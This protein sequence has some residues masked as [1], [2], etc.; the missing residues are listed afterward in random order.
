MDGIAFN[1]PAQAR[2]FSLPAQTGSGSCAA[3]YSTDTA[4]EM[5]QNE[6][7]Y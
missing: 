6:A 4:I 2:K 1:I 3:S 5:V 7:G